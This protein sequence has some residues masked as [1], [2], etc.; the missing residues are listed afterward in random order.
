L[1]WGILLEGINILFSII[2]VLLELHYSNS[3]MKL[4]VPAI[5]LVTIPIMA[6]SEYRKSNNNSLKLIQ[7]IKIVF[8][9]T[10]I[11]SI[12]IVSYKLIFTS[13]I[14]P[15]FYEKYDEINK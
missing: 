3:I 12:L 2:L 13:L 5:I 15:S 14:E 11:A 4:I 1:R 6:I 10:I 9:V 8:I 7:A